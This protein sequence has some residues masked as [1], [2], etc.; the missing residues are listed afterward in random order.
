MAKMAFGKFRRYDN[1]GT[2]LYIPDRV[3]KDEAWP[4][5]DGEV[6][7]IRIDGNRVVQEKAEWW[8]LLDWSKLPDAYAKLPSHIKEQI[9]KAR[10][11]ED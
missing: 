6:V 7:K 3:C 8:E 5:E 4:F 11:S 9:E 2:Q 10:T 1:P